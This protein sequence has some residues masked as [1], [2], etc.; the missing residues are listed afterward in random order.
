MKLSYGENPNPENVNAA[1]LE[2]DQYRVELHIKRRDAHTFLLVCVAGPSGASPKK[3]KAQG[4]FHSY[5]QVSG[6][7]NAIS[8]ALISDGFKV[9]P[10]VP[11]WQ[12]K[13]QAI[14]NDC[15][16]TLNKN[17]GDF[18]FDPKDVL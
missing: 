2:K 14:T 17:A 12:L 9:I 7:S 18:S 11:V 13:A 8:Q 6:C 1:I 15:R 16:D 5:D 4:P 3:Q 10:A